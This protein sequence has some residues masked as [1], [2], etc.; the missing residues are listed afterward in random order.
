MILFFRTP[1]NV[2]FVLNLLICAYLVVRKFR[3][4]NP[5]TDLSFGQT[6]LC[7]SF[8]FIACTVLA[9]IYTY[10]IVEYFKE[11]Q[12]KIKKAM[13]AALTPGI[14]L[15]PTAVAKY[16][17]LR[18]S[19]G[20]FPIDKAFV[21][22]YFLRGGAI[23]LYRTMQSDFQNLWLFIGL[24]LLHGV[25]N[26]LSKATLNLRIKI[27]KCFIRCA[28]KTRCG[29]TLNVQHLDSP[30]IRR[31]NADLEI[32]NILFEY[33]TVILSQ[34]YLVLYIV[35]NFKVDQPW[36]TVKDSLVRICISAGIDFAFNIVSIFIQIHFYDIPMRRVWLRY[37]RRHLIANILII[38][39]MVSYFGF[40]L[41][42]IF[43]ARQDKIQK[44][45]LR[46]CTP[47][48]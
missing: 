38:V 25:S 8:T 4:V 46:N 12:N 45:Q 35:M 32:Q 43:E 40:S 48:I 2:L 1:D 30:R 42:S 26:V 16:L 39:S 21:I 10:V 33:T 17:A 29:A 27:W 11:T 19:L 31:L 24:S 34:A 6:F 5:M 44:Y 13:I 20:V 37:W 15:L 47:L 3:Q 28:N 18:K 14:V 9:Y 23:G 36:E 41:V 7:L 22:C